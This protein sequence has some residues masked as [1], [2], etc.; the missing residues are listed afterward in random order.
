VSFY[1]VNS[2]HERELKMFKTLKTIFLG[3]AN[4]AE[5]ELETA[6]AAIIIEQ[7][8]REAEAG[9]AMAKRGLASL[10]TRSKSEAKA[11][12]VL[13]K[14]MADLEDRIRQALA[15]GKEGL[16][17]DAAA[18][19]AQ[20]ENERN[21][22]ER[23][24]IG[25]KEKAERMRL[26]IEKTHRQLIDLRQGLI[27]AKSIEAERKAIG[28]IKGDISAHSA[29]A[30]GEAVLKR[31]LG[32]PD[33]VDAL[34]ALEEVEADLSGDSVMNRLSAEGFGDNGKVK[35]NDI[36]ERLRNEK[37]GAQTTKSKKAKT[38]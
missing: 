35:A 1:I 17:H 8:I 15:A 18:L 6:H 38:A 29:I 19:L 28:H 24:L 9:H 37:L 11:L 21:V 30:E 4:R 32:N 2:V 23:S 33:P 31:L 10:I 27:T 3:Q 12:E 7:K 26:A 16:A 22:R 36:L 13:E 20:L 34:E 5:Q 25:S 14:R